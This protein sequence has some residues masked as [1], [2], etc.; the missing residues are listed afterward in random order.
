M[1]LSNSAPVCSHAKIITNISHCYGMAVLFSHIYVILE[2]LLCKVDHRPW[3]KKLLSGVVGAVWMTSSW[4]E[5]LPILPAAW[6]EQRLRLSAG[7]GSPGK[8]SGKCG[9]LAKTWRWGRGGERFTACFIITLMH[10]CHVCVWRW[11]LGELLCICRIEFCCLVN[12][13]RR[14][15]SFI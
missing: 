1:S 12:G 6:T 10:P 9:V 5:L 3:Q 8:F 11:C 4:M 14:I 7:T 15:L 13:G 2:Q